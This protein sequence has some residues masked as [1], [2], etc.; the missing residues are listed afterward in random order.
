MQKKTILVVEDDAAMAEVMELILSEEPGYSIHL[1]SDPREA[2]QLAQRI[3]PDLFVLDYLLAHMNGIELYDRLHVSQG[4]ENVPAIIT[5]ASLLMHK[6]L[7]DQRHLIGLEKPF[8]LEVL[9][10]T[11]KQMLA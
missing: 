6:S 2:L 5:S 4:L 3:Q 10:E 9:L 8:D 7:L 11:I 1:V